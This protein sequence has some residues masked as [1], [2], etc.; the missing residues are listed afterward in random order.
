MK[1]G[2]TC[3]VLRSDITKGCSLGGI[4][5]KNDQVLVVMPE[6]GPVSEDDAK[7]LGIPVC[8]VVKR[9]IGGKEYLHVEPDSD[10]MW[11]HG[12]CFIY[13]SDSR[14]PNMYPMSLHDRNMS[15]E[16]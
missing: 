8:K 16:R 7:T 15:L 9:N 2:I 4:S 6:G 1:S 10:G 5:E 13:T 3:L 11:S 14:F 12:G